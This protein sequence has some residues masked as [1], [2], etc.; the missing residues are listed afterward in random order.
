MIR[1]LLVAQLA[2]FLVPPVARASSTHVFDARHIRTHASIPRAVD[3]PAAPDSGIHPRR[4]ADAALQAASNGTLDQW[5]KPWADRL[6][7]NPRDRTAMFANAAAFR[8]RYDFTRADSLYARIYAAGN[9][10]ALASQSQLWRTLI[11]VNSGRYSQAGSELLAIE[12]NALRR[13]DTLT[14]L[15]AILARSGVVARTETAN[16]A[17][18]VMAHGDSLN[19]RRDAGLDASARCRQSAL[20]SRLGNR[21]RARALAREGVAIAT[22]A[23]LPRIAATCLFTLATDFARV[24]LTD[25]LSAPL[26]KAIAMQEKA[27]DLAGV[28]AS[29]QW[30]GF[31]LLSLGNIPIALSHLSAAWSAAQR[32]K[33]PLTAAW[34]ALNYAGVA[35]ALYDAAGNSM[36]L[37][38]ADSLM[39][40]VDDQSGI[41]EVLRSQATRAQRAGDYETSAKYSREAKA[42]ADRFGE[43]TLQLSL[44]SALWE[45]AMGRG[46]LDAVAVI[47]DERKQLVEKYKLTGWINE[48]INDQ[49]ELALRRKQPEKALP[50][51][52][53]A[54]AGMHPSQKKF[55]F[56]AEEER[57]LALSQTGDIH[58]AAR[59]ALEAAETFDTWR[60]SLSDQTLQS[61]SVSARRG[62]GWYTSSL[63]ANLTDGGEIEVAFSL[64][65]RRRARELRDRLAL[66]ASLRTDSRAAQV[67][68]SQPPMAVADLQRALPDNQTALIMMDAGQDGARGTAF[69][70]TKQALSAHPLP[71]VDDIAP[72]VRRLVSL[73]EAGR[74]ANVEARALGSSLIAPLLPRLDS[75][76]ITRL[77]FLPEGVLHR[78]PFDVLRLPDGRFLIERFETAVAP[79][80]TVL[81]RLAS[82]TQKAAGTTRVLAFA[83]ALSSPARGGDSISDSPLFVSLFG[84]ASMLPRLIG[85][86]TEVAAVKR[87]MPTTVIKSGGAATETTMKR[88]AASYDVLHFATHAVVDEWSGASAALA[89]TPTTTDDGLFDSSEIARLHLSASLVVLSACRTV[90][91]EVI[92]GEGVHGLTTAF[93]QAGARSVI[94][95]AWRVNDRD[96]VPVVTSLYEQL[97][98]GRGVGAALRAAQVSAIKRNVP[99]SVWGAFTLV[100]DPWRVVTAGR[101]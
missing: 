25:S 67:P 10:D 84:S 36:W 88:D 23:E 34:V 20:Y 78:L 2:L 70:L 50:L 48:T 74:D 81:A 42:I 47:T 46:D 33:T 96:V 3:S 73:L 72:R 69:V 16:S 61:F 15:D 64:A 12:R 97:A 57:A 21:E 6:R 77:V 28:A 1:L 79:S 95:T 66:A 54:I 43:P 60:A 83:D 51:L 39:R 14:A 41:V 82:Q 40:A 87:A 63:T 18:A 19:W 27:G 80:A 68:A 76:A 8:L 31:Y 35:Q 5:T 56:V 32:A 13:G 58:G 59:A 99:P 22:R 90:G 38:R 91:G 52:A 93:L 53:K 65:E 71:T 45:D 24:G 101:R 92:A 86:R 37:G 4:L 11:R 26:H 62:Q 75:A 94:A 49:A 100:G 85:A 17:L 44:S 98:R 9:A 7:A 89:L 30:A 55:I 29:R